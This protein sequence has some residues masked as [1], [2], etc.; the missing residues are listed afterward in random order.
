MASLSRV[1]SHLLTR[2]RVTG[3]ADDKLLC[4]LGLSLRKR[5]QLQYPMVRSHKDSGCAV[6]LQASP[7]EAGL[8]QIRCFTRCILTG[9]RRRLTGLM[10]RRGA[11]SPRPV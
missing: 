2:R 1:R 10:V 6:C 8:R 11:I 9:R 5:F 3:S 7:P 4:I